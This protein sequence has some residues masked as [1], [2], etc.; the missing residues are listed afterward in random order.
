MLSGRLYKNTS[1]QPSTYSKNVTHQV[2]V[3]RLVDNANH[4][5]NH[6]P[7]DSVVCFVD[8]VDSYSGS[9][10]T[11]EARGTNYATATHAIGSSSYDHHADAP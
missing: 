2:Q 11:T 9:L 5:I 8:T 1:L 6:Y 7:V 10:R 4:Q 3:V